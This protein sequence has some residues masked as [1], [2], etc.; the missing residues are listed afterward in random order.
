MAEISIR[1]EKDVYTAGGRLAGL[2]ALV[3]E[4]AITVRGLRAK[5]EGWEEPAAS[6]SRRVIAE[7]IVLTGRERFSSRLEALADLW[8][9][10]LGRRSHPKLQP[11]E[12]TYPFAIDLPADLPPSRRDDS[13]TV[14]YELSAYADVPLAANPGAFRGI[15]VVSAEPRGGQ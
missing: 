7:E 5:L 2:V 9:L 4:R 6:P 11:G 10:L 1:L 8:G 3:T 15:I 13:G 14:F 12:Y